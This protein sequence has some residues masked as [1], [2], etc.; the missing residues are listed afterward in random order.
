MPV[1]VAAIAVAT[2]EALEVLASIAPT[3]TVEV[4]FGTAVAQMPLSPLHVAR[5]VSVAA[6]TVV[7]RG[8]AVP[9]PMLEPVR[10]VPTAWFVIVAVGADVPW[11]SENR[12]E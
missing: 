1:A 12:A 9:V 6:T 5:L 4:E 10:A 11:L 8:K 2:P 3:I 7:L